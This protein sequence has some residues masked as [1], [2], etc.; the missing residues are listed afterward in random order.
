[1]SQLVRTSVTSLFIVQ[2]AASYAWS[3]SSP[4]NSDTGA[5]EEI[6][7]TAE[8]RSETLQSVPISVSAFTASQ[9]EARGIQNTENLAEFTPGLQFS[10]NTILG[11][12]YI[13]GIG[14]NQLNIGSDPDVA[15]NVDGVYIARPVGAIQNFL[16]VD[17]VEVLKGPQGTLYGRNAT[18]GAI[19]IISKAPTPDLTGA[20][21][22]TTGNYGDFE[23]T[24]TISGP[25]VPGDVLARLTLGHTQHDPYLKNRYAAAGGADSGSYDQGRATID[26]IAADDFTIR[27]QA[28]GLTEHDTRGDAGVVTVPGPATL[29]FNEPILSGGR[30]IDV[31]VPVHSFVD[32]YGVSVTANYTFDDL[33]ATSISAY[34]YSNFNLDLDFDFTDFSFAYNNPELEESNS[35][36]QELRLASSDKE[37]FYWTG[38]VYFLHEDGTTSNDIFL[39]QSHVE[40]NPVGASHTDAYAAFG[41]MSYRPT[42]DV[43]LTGGLRYS[44]ENRSVFVESFTNKALKSTFDRSA[45]Y[46]SVTPKFVI[47]YFF[48]PGVMTYFSATRGFKSGGFNATSTTNPP[49]L[50]EKVWA[51]EIG[52]KS[53]FL[54]KRLRINAAAFHYDYT[55]LQVIQSIPGQL[56]KITNAASATIDGAELEGIASITP[57]FRLNASL[58]L[59]DATYGDYKTVD[60]DRPQLGVLNLKGTTLP[61]SP[62][63]T[64][65]LGAEY[66]WDG[67]WGTISVRG[68]YSHTSKVSFTQFDAPFVTQKGYGLLNARATYTTPDG[69]W[70]FSLWAQNLTD[71]YYY[72]VMLENTGFYGVVSL[73]GPPRT[74]GATGRYNF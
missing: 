67:D 60:S 21:A 44:I 64:F 3:A 40:S 37:R 7:I 62:H 46:Y 14:S 22:A 65:T 28:D 42:D 61:R 36:T 20:V 43:R 74:F 48:A 58:A 29:R 9:L 1:M 2:V 27:V 39:P 12:P 66:L 69:N 72:Q 45:S 68:D 18:G 30:N 49:F 17:H 57:Q 26:F 13:R 63:T 35:V 33:T 24:G 51:Y 34:R 59:L 55:D 52:V 4:D 54:D 6:V 70:D 38:G 23:A 47:D 19:N 31:N 71:T 16:D 53:T 11:Q 32:E 10:N 5:I 56:S 15:V 41:Q 73:P 8:K 25:L 50:P